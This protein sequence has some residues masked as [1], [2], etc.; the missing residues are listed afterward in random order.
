MC[1]DTELLIR[2]LGVPENEGCLQ[3]DRQ[4][5]PSLLKVKTHAMLPMQTFSPALK[6]QTI[7]NTVC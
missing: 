2:W 1:G 3:Q 5:G 6:L 7:I 4:Y